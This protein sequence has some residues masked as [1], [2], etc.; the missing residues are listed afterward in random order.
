MLKDD[1]G[2]G[3]DKSAEVQLDGSS[4]RL[5]FDEGQLWMELSGDPYLLRP[6][7]QCSR[8]QRAL[9]ARHLSNMWEALN[10]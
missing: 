8:D 1:H 9:A 7:K 4:W 6:L 3:L 2:V 5:L 10:A